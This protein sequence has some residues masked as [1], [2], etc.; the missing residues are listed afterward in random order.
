MKNT[1]S[2]PFGRLAL[3]WVRKSETPL[4]IGLDA[5]NLFLLFRHP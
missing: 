3:T 4:P 5:V 1:V 2:A